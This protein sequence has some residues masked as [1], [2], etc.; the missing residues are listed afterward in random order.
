MQA[1]ILKHQRLSFHTNS[2]Q[3]T[4]M[5]LDSCSSCSSCCHR[6]LQ[7]K[8]QFQ[9][10]SQTTG[11]MA[12]ATTHFCTGDACFLHELSVAQRR[13]HAFYRLQ[14]EPR[15]VVRL[16]PDEVK[17]ACE[18]AYRTAS[19]VLLYIWKSW[20]APIVYSSRKLELVSPRSQLRV[21]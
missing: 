13:V 18:R 21:N 16:T 19:R 17:T 11:N 12:S 7:L 6:M 20:G 9:Y 4:C 10:F 5:E 2:R 1:A 8:R 15:S 14:T 3:S